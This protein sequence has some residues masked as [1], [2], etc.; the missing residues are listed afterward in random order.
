[1]FYNRAFTNDS[2]EFEI[3]LASVD[4]IV[5]YSKAEEPPNYKMTN[6]ELEYSCIS[7]NYL[8]TQALASYRVGKGFTYEDI[9]LHKTFKI[10]RP[11]DDKIFK[12]VNVPRRS[13][14]GILCLFT[15][16]YTPGNRDSETFV[17]PEITSI[18]INLDGIPNQFYSKG[19]NP[20]DL[21]RSA[22][23]RFGLNDSIKEE[24]FYMDKFALWIDLR[25][26]PDNK[27]HGNGYS[28]NDSYNG[29]TLEIDREKGGTGIITC[30][31]FL[32]SDA[33]MDV[34]NLNL[35]QIIY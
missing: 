18:K 14:T 9:I 11:N 5:V 26:Y 10:S 31:M 23:K 16:S 20:T 21:W 15:N 4:D 33:V 12:H 7:S 3:T 35:K 24:D 1:M 34:Q 27:I 22:I 8:T 17:N 6:I 2:L 28:L 25:S 30:Y 32:V 13:M 29:V 19:M